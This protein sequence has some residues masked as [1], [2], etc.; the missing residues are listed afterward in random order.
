MLGSIL[1]LKDL[2]QRT[3]AIYLKQFESEWQYLVLGSV[4]CTLSLVHSDNG[5]RN[6]QVI[7]QLTHFR[8]AVDQSTPHTFVLFV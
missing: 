2:F 7:L 6:I 8:K 3:I 4:S 5:G 1:R